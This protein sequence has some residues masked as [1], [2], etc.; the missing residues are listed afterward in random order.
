MNARPLWKDLAPLCLMVFAEF[1]A[2]GLPLPVL[3][4]QVH[5]QLGFGAFVV[6]LVIGAQSW[7][8]LLTRHYA[9]TRTDARGPKSAA[10]LG[11]SLSMLAGSVMALSSVVPHG[12][13]SLG[14]LLLGRALLG[15]GESLVVTSALGWGVALAGRERS[16]VVMAW[17]GIAMYGALAAGSPLGVAAHASQGFVGTALF[18]A[19][20]PAL[21]LLAVLL[22]R[23]VSPVGGTRLPFH[24]VAGLIW[25]PGA[26]LALSALGFGAIAAFST[27]RFHERGWAHAELAMSAF[28]AAYVLARLFFAKL[29]DR[30]GG[31]RVALGSTAVV[32]LGQTLSW[33]ASSGEQAVLGA[34]LTGFGFSLAFPS[35]GVEAI[36]Q[37]PPQNR[38]VAL[39]AYAACF[40]LTMGVG[41]PLLGLV[42]AGFGQ[43]AV[44]IAGAGSAV[45]AFIIAAGLVAKRLT[46]SAQPNA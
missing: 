30:F 16:G 18:A 24:R 25:R 14:V 33:F 29:P 28:G 42:A 4:G 36:T 27:L 22:V 46:L 5:A 38:G 6:G 26:G 3:P 32:V 10:V 39:G 15:L 13:A 9:G 40:D 7:A 34:A 20:A 21:G 17:V 31:A 37:V 1:L 19:A 12:G 35:F 2:M 45:L 43:D 41:V 23:P 11:L 8:T 44:L